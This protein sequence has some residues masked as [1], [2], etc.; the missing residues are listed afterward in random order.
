M[1]DLSFSSENTV[2]L[3]IRPIVTI[4]ANTSL[5]TYNSNRD[6]TKEKPW[7]LD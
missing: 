5:Y 7:L 4:K 1:D 2:G 6:G 3:R